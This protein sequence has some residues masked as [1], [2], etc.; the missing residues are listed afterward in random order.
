MFDSML[1]DLKKSG[2]SLSFWNSSSL[3]KELS[4]TP[5]WIFSKRNAGKV[6]K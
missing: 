1:S 6:W 5:F 3:K 2:K 4:G